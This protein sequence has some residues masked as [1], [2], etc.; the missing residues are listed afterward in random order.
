[1][2]FISG[3]V[4]WFN[5][6]K[7]FGFIEYK[8]GED[9]FVHYSQIKKNGYKKWELT[10]FATNYNYI[11]CGVGGKLFKYFIK[12]ENP[13]EIKS[14]ADRRWT[15]SDEESLYNKLGF[16]VDKII[17][18]NYYYIKENKVKRYHKFNMRKKLLDK[19]YGEKYQVNMNMTENEITKKIG[20]YRIY[21]CGLIKY[22][23]KKEN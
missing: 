19:K 9:V 10:R 11:C 23:W 1:M 2:F 13:D 18:P 8:E 6:E 21:D 3:L 16:K 22:I 15:L 12:T 17:P 5:N 20:F 7:G 4:K 14:F